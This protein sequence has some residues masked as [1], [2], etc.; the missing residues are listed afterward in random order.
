MT[1]VDSTCSFVPYIPNEPLA[2]FSRVYYECHFTKRIIISDRRSN[3]IFSI[4]C[5]IE[6]LFCKTEKSSIIWENNIVNKCPMHEIEKVR[7]ERSG[8]FLTNSEKS[9][10]FTLGEN[11][12]Y[13]NTTYVKSKEGVFLKEIPFEE[14]SFFLKKNFNF[15]KYG[16]INNSFNNN[17]ALCH[18]IF[19]MIK[20]Y[21]N[22]L[23]FFKLKDFDGN[24]FIFFAK[25]GLI[26]IPDCSYIQSIE[27]HNDIKECTNELPV[28]YMHDKIKKIGYLTAQNVLTNF[29]TAADCNS[30]RYFFFKNGQMVELYGKNVTFKKSIRIGR[31]KSVTFNG[32]SFLLNLISMEQSKFQENRM[33]L[34][35][36]RLILPTLRTEMNWI[37]I[38]FAISL[39]IFSILLIICIIFG[40]YYFI[41]Y[42][43]KR[44]NN[45]AEFTSHC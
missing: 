11:V 40:V 32:H 42:L 35:E 16:L 14:K 27:V 15:K 22:S 26:Q 1:C 37:S 30:S 28:F 7:F 20:F 18:M 9:Y 13:C 43:K 25:N 21:S 10:S 29:S 31:K 33:K 23:G 3:Q 45:L 2:E 4:T 44:I 5:N 8:D 34:A 12:T 36:N 39:L 6:D 41:I 17:E 24:E 38:I 19:L